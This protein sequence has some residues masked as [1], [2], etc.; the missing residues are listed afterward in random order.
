MFFLWFMGI[1]VI[2]YWWVEWGRDGGF[3]L[4]RLGNGEFFIGWL[5]VLMIV[6]LYIVCL[7]SV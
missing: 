1:K 7:I 5:K 3:G 6:R 2:G 4:G